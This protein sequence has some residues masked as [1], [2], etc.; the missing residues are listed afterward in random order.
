M[1]GVKIT[2]TTQLICVG[3]KTTSYIY[4]EKSQTLS[5]VPVP[6]RMEEA[7]SPRNCC[8][9]KKGAAAGVGAT[10]ETA[11][12]VKRPTDIG[13]Y[14]LSQRITDLRMRVGLVE[15]GVLQ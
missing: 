8:L 10:R 14:R 4:D 2:F 13:E 5:R 1:Q 12:I 15:Q 3:N 7:N 11:L 6:L 9:P